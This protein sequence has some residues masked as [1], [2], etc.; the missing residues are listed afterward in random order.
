MAA[1]PRSVLLHTTYE[2]MTSAEV[3]YFDHFRHRVVHQLGCAELWFHTILCESAR[4]GGILDCIIAIGA[5][6]LAKGCSR[7]DV[8]LYKAHLSDSQPLRAHYCVAIKHYA[9]AL[10]YFQD[11]VSPPR[12]APQPRTVLLSSILACTFEVF[13]GNTAA[14]DKLVTHGIRTIQALLQQTS[15]FENAQL[16]D[17][18]AHE[19]VLFLVRSASLLSLSSPMYKTARKHAME[20]PYVVLPQRG[21]PGR[22]HTIDEFNIYSGQVAA[23]VMSWCSQSCFR[24]TADYLDIASMQE[25]QWKFLSL[26]TR[27]IQSAQQRLDHE[28]KTS[29]KEGLKLIILGYKILIPWIA[30]CGDIHGTPWEQY[31]D[32]CLEIVTFCQSFFIHLASV[33]QT[34]M[35]DGL[36]AAFVQILGRCRDFEVRVAAIRTCKQLLNTSLGWDIRIMLL[37]TLKLAEIEECERIDGAIPLNSRRE[38][39]EAS[40]SHDDQKLHVSYKQILGHEFESH[41]LNSNLY[42][43]ESGLIDN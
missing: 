7:E 6:V 27:S 40:L 28:T 2:K 17:R 24:Q 10:A 38:W 12:S 29:A 8:P 35:C 21:M 18:G 9:K 26:I 22:E 14:V 4:D 41:E 43:G 31:R 37:A 33:K 32:T 36:L 5:L 34:I 39:T 30:S 16:P 13:Q 23:T 20:Y 1:P 42:L 3:N 11:H 25:E 19:A 15:L